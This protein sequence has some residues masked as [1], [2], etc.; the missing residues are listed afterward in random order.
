MLKITNLRVSSREGKQ[1]LKDV[2]LSLE[3]GARICLTGP[4][5]A[6]KSTLIRVI[7]GI[8]GDGISVLSGDVQLDEKSILK[9]KSKDRRDLCGK[10][11]GFIPQNSMFL[12]IDYPRLK[13]SKS[14]LLP[15]V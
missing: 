7:M 8:G 4:S 6:G 1:L 12:F 10:T 9:L 2:S 11:F 5:G 15:Y 13:R 3:Q 14:A